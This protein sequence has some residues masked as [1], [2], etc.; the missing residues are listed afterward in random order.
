[1]KM[2]LIVALVLVLLAGATYARSCYYDDDCYSD[3]Y[4]SGG[5]CKTSSSSCCGP[6]SILGA[7]VVGAFMTSKGKMF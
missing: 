7:L 5:T 2:L 3:E 6:A 1:M 4:C